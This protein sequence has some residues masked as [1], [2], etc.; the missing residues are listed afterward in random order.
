MAVAAGQ[1]LVLRHRQRFSAGHA[2]LPFDEIDAGDHLGDGVLDLQ[3]GVHLE[4]EELAVLVDE[5]DRAGVVVAD[6]LGHLD[7]RRAHGIF[8]TAAPSRTPG[9]LDQLLVTAL[10]GAVAGADPH[11]V[12]VLVADDL[13]LDVARP[14]EVALDVDLVAAEER[15]RLALGAVHGRL[16]L[17]GC[18]HH[19]HAAPAA[20]ERGLD[21]QRDSRARRRRR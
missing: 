10:G 5:L 9:L 8:D 18:A 1:H 13:H 17:V 4:E 16:H 11:H 20:A 7:G 21:R 15:L 14:R 19:L 12:A 2:D 6:G 3:A